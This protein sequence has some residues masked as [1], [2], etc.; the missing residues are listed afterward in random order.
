MIV[1]WEYVV[2]GR[3]LAYGKVYV[4]VR[5]HWW[6]QSLKGSLKAIRDAIINN[7]SQSV[8]I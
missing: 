4:I 8:P 6:V 3:T 7:Q 5:V 2:T 1:I